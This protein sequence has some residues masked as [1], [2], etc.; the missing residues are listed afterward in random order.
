MLI[1]VWVPY[2]NKFGTNEQIVFTKDGEM[3]AQSVT[4][5]AAKTER[6]L[7]FKISDNKKILIVDDGEK[8]EQLEIIELNNSTLKLKRYSKSDT[9]IFNR[10]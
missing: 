1:G 2:N 7:K 4:D 8:K 3:L 9:A 6:T 10:K 5:N